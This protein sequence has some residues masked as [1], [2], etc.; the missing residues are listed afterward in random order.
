PCQSISKEY[1]SAGLRPDIMCMIIQVHT[2]EAIFPLY[3]DKRFCHFLE[4]CLVFQTILFTVIRQIFQH[5]GQSGHCPAIASCP[6]HLFPIRADLLIIAAAGRVIYCARIINKEHKENYLMW[7][8][9]KEIPFSNNV[10]ERSLRSSKTK[11]KVSGQFENIN[12][13]RNYANIKSYL[14]TGKR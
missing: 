5:S 4:R 10:S 13:A 3:L 1:R 12:S 11:M 6:E 7:T 2:P 9:N 14:E 8:L